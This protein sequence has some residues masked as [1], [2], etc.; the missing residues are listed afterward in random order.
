MQ[1]A[2]WI[3]AAAIA[4]AFP[5]GAAIAGLAYAILRRKWSDRLIAA[6]LTVL[7]LVTYYASAALDYWGA[8][9]HVMLSLTRLSHEPVTAGEWST[10]VG[11]GAAFGPALGAIL[12]MVLP[13]HRER[14]PFN[15]ADE[16]ERRQLCEERRRRDRRRPLPVHRRAR[17]RRTP[18]RPR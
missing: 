2:R 3:S 18:A 4:V 17:S 1:R 13:V 5:V 15:G 11:L 10:V 6:V 12:W 8:W 14:S 7:G 9:R 16:R